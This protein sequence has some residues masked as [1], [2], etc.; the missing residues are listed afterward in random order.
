ML[1]IR[2]GLIPL[3]ALIVVSLNSALLWSFSAGGNIE[4]SGGRDHAL[5]LVMAGRLES[6][7]PGAKMFRAA[8]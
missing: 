1:Q 3:I 6:G 7:R 8:R 5:M 4:L 2:L